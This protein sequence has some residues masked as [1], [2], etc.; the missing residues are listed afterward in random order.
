M[1]S[2]LNIFI[3]SHIHC[4]PP[5]QII[6]RPCPVP[7]PFIL[8]SIVI[9]MA[10]LDP[11]NL[12]D[13][14][15]DPEIQKLSGH[16]KLLGLHLGIKKD[17]LDKILFGKCMNKMLEIFLENE[18][19]PTWK[20]VKKALS[21]TR[22][23][24]EGK[25][26]RDTIAQKE[27][28]AK[29][30]T[31]K[32]LAALQE[33]ETIDHTIAEKLKKMDDKLEK[34][35]RG[36][37]DEEG[38]LKEKNESVKRMREGIENAEGMEESGDKHNKLLKEEIKL[39]KLN[40]RFKTYQDKHKNKVESIHQ[41]IEEWKGKIEERLDIHKNIVEKLGVEQEIVNHQEVLENMFDKCKRLRE[42]CETALEES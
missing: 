1:F 33:W 34:E 8:A 6:H 3:L 10:A 12:K 7:H 30:A 27:L 20:T 15:D 24:L 11:P 31:R 28:V 35:N 17:C 36:L 19:N 25:D 29:E 41:E 16:W 14:M 2:L 42:Q 9:E 37:K 38:K 21:V 13:L 40:K 5:D 32:V 4:I 22:M 26:E 23:K 18:A 39:S